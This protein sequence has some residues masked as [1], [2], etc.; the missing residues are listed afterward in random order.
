[1]SKSW[2]TP[3]LQKSVSVKNRSLSDFIKKGIVQLKQNFFKI[4]KSWKFNISPFEKK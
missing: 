2:I 4:Q 1:M 3:G